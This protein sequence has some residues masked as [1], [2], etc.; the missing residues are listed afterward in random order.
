ME[1]RGNSLWRGKDKVGSWMVKRKNHSHGAQVNSVCA[2]SAWLHF[3]IQEP[4]LD[5][6]RTP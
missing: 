6:N 3:L 5:N 1:G 4:L 2:V